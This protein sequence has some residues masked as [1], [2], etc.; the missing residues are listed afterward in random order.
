M[1]RLTESFGN[2]KTDAEK[3]Y[4]QNELETYTKRFANAMNI[5][6]NSLKNML[7]GKSKINVVQES[8]PSRKSSPT[9]QTSKPFVNS[10]GEA[11]RRVITSLSYNRAQKRLQKQ[12]NSMFNW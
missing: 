10:D 4:Y 8:T 1:E 3:T 9:T 2:A 7:I 6:E 5:S 11:T 12:I